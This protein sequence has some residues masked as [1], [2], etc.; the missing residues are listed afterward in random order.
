MCPCSFPV[1][2]AFSVN[3]QLSIKFNKGHSTEWKVSYELV[4]NFYNKSRD[5]M[6]LFEDQCFRIYAK[7]CFYLKRAT[8][9]TSKILKSYLLSMIPYLLSSMQWNTNQWQSKLSAEFMKHIW[10]F[11]QFHES[12]QHK[13]IAQFDFDT[14]WAMCFDTTW[15]NQLHKYSITKSY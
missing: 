2:F 7:L 11:C 5:W 14:L 4:F 12:K 10:S 9:S 3:L 1:K 8:N 13:V 15:P 6:S